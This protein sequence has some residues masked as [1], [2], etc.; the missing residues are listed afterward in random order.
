MKSIDTIKNK[1][2]AGLFASVLGKSTIDPNSHEYK[3]IEA[4]TE[5]LLIHGYGV[6]HGG[7]AGGAMS[8]VSDTANVY[9]TKNHLSPH[10]N[11]AVPQKQHDGIWERVKE[12]SF[13]D[14]CDDIYERLK[15]VTSGDISVICPL[16]GDGA[17]LEETIVFHE[18][19]VR[20]GMNK[21]GNGKEKMVP[22][23]FV[24]TQHGTNW[25]HLVNQKIATL[26]TSAKSIDDYSWLY[27]V[28]SVDSFENLIKELKMEIV[29]ETQLP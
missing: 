2:G 28:D 23:I 20:E 16:G 7:Y 14:I 3:T 24:Q 12:A 15:L 29:H 4:I 1:S 17:E 5:K 18:N 11:I 9:I 8:A 27:F 22:L 19:V 26:C 10:L 13:T 21:Y 6:I 25:K